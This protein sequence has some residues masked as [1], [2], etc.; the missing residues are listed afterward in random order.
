MDRALGFG[1]RG[2][3]F[4]SLRGYETPRAGGGLPVSCPR[5]EATGKAMQAAILSIGSELI[6]G[7]LADT[8]APFLARE[9][10]ALGI[11]L[12]GVMQVGDDRGRIARAL[13]RAWEDAELVITTGGLGP[14]E[15]DLTREAIGDLLGKAPSVDA[16][17]LDTIE[18]YFAARGAPMPP[19]NVK[20]AWLIPSAVALPNPIGTAPGWFVRHDGRAIVAMPGVPREMWRMWREQAVPQLASLLGDRIVVSRTLKAIGIGESAAEEMIIDIIEREQPRVATYAKDD[21]LHIRITAVT[22]DREEGEQAVSRT[23]QEI[24]RILSQ[25][26]YGDDQ[27]SLPAA[28]LAPLDRTNQTLAT[29]DVGSAG[30]LAGLLS[31]DPAAEARYRGGLVRSFE[32]AASSQ[33]VDGGTSSAAREI[34]RR[35]AEAARSLLDAELGLALVV[36][37]TPGTAP[38]RARVE[39]ALGLTG[40][41][42]V[43]ERQHELIGAPAEVRRRAGL[44]AVD[45]L[46]DTLGD[47]AR[48]TD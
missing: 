33:G 18:A 34:A 19:R 6:D 15:D 31:G 43:R 27:V 24:R 10:V 47:L 40:A 1:P 36:H 4:E 35:E 42:S 14:T 32:Q 12:T 37:L 38:D 21:G 20:Q 30:F 13:R 48:P 5:G 2:W 28:L 44:W 39:I 8:N 45:F 25:Y 9:L 26:V 16:G 22:H 7:F 17:L 29:S 46:R 41:S 11:E 23:E 3:G